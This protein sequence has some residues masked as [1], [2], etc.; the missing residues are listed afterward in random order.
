MPTL[1]LF[2][3]PP[4]SGKTTAAELICKLTGATHI[5][6][7]RE[8]QNMFGRPTHSLAESAELYKALNLKTKHLLQ[9]GHDV[10]FDTNFNYRADR[11]RLHKIA[12]EAGADTVII[13]MVTPEAL[14]RER[15]LAWSHADRNGMHREMSVETFERIVKHRQPLVNEITPVLLDGR[16]L[17]EASVKKALG[18]K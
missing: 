17:S 10:V 5:W 18:L 2:V 15:A 11:Q 4:G 7:D 14:A 6:A 1:H 12:E 9:A 8:R 16:N 3:G 13:Q